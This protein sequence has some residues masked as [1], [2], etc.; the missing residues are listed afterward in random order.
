MTTINDLRQWFRH[1]YGKR[2]YRFT[3]NGDIYICANN[4][5]PACEPV[6]VAEPETN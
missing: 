4:C 1:H 6:F 2:N 3:S 5:F